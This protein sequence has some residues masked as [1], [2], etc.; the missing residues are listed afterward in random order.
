M[1]TTATD[2]L[3]YDDDLD[4]QQ[5]DP[6]GG[7]DPR[8]RN[9]EGYDRRQ[10]GKSQRDAEL[11]ELR[12]FKEQVE[13]ERALDSAKAELNA[14]GPLG[15]FLRTYNGEPN[16]EAIKAA[17]AKDPDFRDLIAFPTDPRDEAAAT[18]AAATAAVKGG[19]PLG[20]SNLTEHVAPGLGRLEAAY[21]KRT[22]AKT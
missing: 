9:R 13:R 16:A 19:A 12:A 6:Q 11:A 20:A 4:D 17:V 22:P 15:A 5:D 1:P 21:A 18:Q 3:G 8:A 7:D 14:S 10:R 2:D